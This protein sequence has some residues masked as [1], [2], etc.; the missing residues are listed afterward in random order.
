[1]TQKQSTST[2]TRTDFFKLPSPLRHLFDTFPLITY[3][4]NAIPQRLKQ[5][6]HHHSLY[7][8]TYPPGT[9]NSQL[10]PN[11]ACLKWQAYLHTRQV[12][13]R[14]VSS[15]NHASPSGALPYLQSARVSTNEPGSVQI[16]SSKL[17]RWTESQTGTID[18]QDVRLDAYMALI[19][20][21]IRNAWLYYMY[22]NQENLRAVAEKIYITPIS[23]SNSVRSILKYQLQQAAKEQLQRTTPTL[24]EE[25]IL[26]SAEVAFRSLNT[27]LG[28]D[29]FFSK[30]DV[31]GLFDCALFAYT[32]PLLALSDT[33]YDSSIRWADDALVQK[34]LPYEAL[35]RHTQN[36]LRICGDGQA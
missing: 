1:M 8:F 32:Q 7:V 14:I 28:H 24:D 12:P 3:D 26:D 27:L 18:E 17:L 30:K 34:I 22:L 13:F 11:P 5:A 9:S 25:D 21:N 10:S 36:M 35:I 31:P 16:T 29:T 15:S 20:Q 33:R 2:N 19:D 23:R 6:T 4:Q